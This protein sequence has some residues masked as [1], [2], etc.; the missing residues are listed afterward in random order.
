MDLEIEQSPLESKFS[1]QLQD[2][3]GQ[4]EQICAM[5]PDYVQGRAAQ[6][7]AA[8][9]AKV[10][11]LLAVETKRY[12]ET[13][14][15]YN[16]QRWQ[17]L[18]R[19][20]AQEQSR[21]HEELDA[22]MR[23]VAQHVGAAVDAAAP[24]PADGG[25]DASWAW[26]S[27][28]SPTAAQQ[29]ARPAPGGDD[30]DADRRFDDAERRMRQGRKRVIQRRFNWRDKEKQSRL[31]HTAPVFEPDA[32]QDG[33]MP[34]I[35]VSGRD[36]GGDKRLFSNG[37]QPRARSPAK[38]TRPGAPARPAAAPAVAAA[39]ERQVAELRKGYAKALDRVEFQKAN[40]KKWIHRQ[41]TR[42]TI[43]IDACDPVCRFLA[44]RVAAATE[45][46]GSKA[47]QAAAFDA[48]I[49]AHLG[50]TRAASEAAAAQAA[51]SAAAPR[52]AAA[53]GLGPGLPLQNHA[54]FGARRFGRRRPPTSDAVVR[55]GGRSQRNPHHLQQLSKSFGGSFPASGAGA[56]PYAKAGG[57]RPNTSGAPSR[58]R[59]R[60]GFSPI[61]NAG[62]RKGVDAS[63][64]GEASMKATPLRMHVRAG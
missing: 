35:A 7:A 26:P 24:E 34:K 63:G 3:M 4:E 32:Q 13:Q 59:V 28:S 51:P 29:A 27:A 43:Q 42:M 18:F 50:A 62:A 23:A 11:E 17:S 15:R 37:S 8:T 52:S 60:G 40:A 30:A 1:A 39:A 22:R 44:S 49:K 6:Q 14:S 48:R 64:L 45:S 57:R 9:F 20:H 10:D 19:R 21:F 58:G 2:L 33:A 55:G 5:G 54:A 38:G 31:V 25:D 36:E 53:P 41:K 61:H 46:D 56:N 12:F 16:Q 47:R